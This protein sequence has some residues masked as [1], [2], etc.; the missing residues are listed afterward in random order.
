MSVLILLEDIRNWNESLLKNLA[1]SFN[2]R[3]VSKIPEPESDVFKACTKAGCLLI[4]SDTLGQHQLILSWAE[5][6]GR[7]SGIPVLEISEKFEVS[8]SFPVTDGISGFRKINLSSGHEV[9]FLIRV[10]S[11]VM[12]SGHKTGMIDSFRDLMFDSEKRCII[13]DGCQKKEELTPKEARLLKLMLNFPGRCFSRQELREYVWDGAKVS[14]RSIDSQ[15]SRL[16]KKLHGSQ[17]SISNR[18]GDGYILG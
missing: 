8:S 14:P 3:H 16:R 11:D 18:Y 5:T 9:E 1:S 2:L 17:I 6:L 10:I 12:E 13:L 15:V 7:I 4:H